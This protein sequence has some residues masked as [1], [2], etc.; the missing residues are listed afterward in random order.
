LTPKLS[1]LIPAAGASVRLGEPKQL[2]QYRGVPLLQR[3][4]DAVKPLSPEQLIVVTGAF[5][6]ALRIAVT[7]TAID[8]VHNAGWRD[9][10]GSSIAAGAAAAEP[11]TDGLL[12]LLCDQWQVQTGD[13]QALLECWHSDPSRIVTATA[14]GR[15]MPPVIFP[16]KLF[17]RLRNLTG[18]QGARH[19]LR[20]HAE[21]IR[22]VAIE[23]AIHDLDTAVDLD[24]LNGDCRNG[25]G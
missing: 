1:I 21:L 24:M 16:A 19:V 18:D 14:G 8:W 9:G 25:P 7:D 4:V 10:M 3:A 22:T 17:A 11:G 5:D 23:N 13:L 2:V 20:D 12:I 6:K 15:T